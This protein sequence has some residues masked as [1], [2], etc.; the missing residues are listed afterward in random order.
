MI[1]VGPVSR[2]SITSKI[3]SIF[4]VQ[5]KRRDT[6]VVC[7]LF[8]LN[9]QKLKFS[10]DEDDDKSKENRIKSRG[11]ISLKLDEKISE[12]KE[13]EKE[14]DFRSSKVMRIYC[15]INKYFQRL[16]LILIYFIRSVGKS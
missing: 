5:K 16:C 14:N 10:D 13:N 4:Y 15:V 6:K 7:F 12:K 2:T 8:V 3:Y 11:K 1:L 9:S